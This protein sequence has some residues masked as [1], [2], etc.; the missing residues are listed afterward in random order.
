MHPPLTCECC[1]LSL[2]RDAPASTTHASSASTPPA[3]PTRLSLDRLLQHCSVASRGPCSTGASAGT[4]SQS[5]ERLSRRELQS[6]GIKG[7]QP[8]K[9]LRGGTA[10]VIAG[11]KLSELSSELGAGLIASPWSG[12]DPSRLSESGTSSKVLLLHGL[13]LLIQPCLPLLVLVLLL[14]L[15]L[16]R[17]NRAIADATLL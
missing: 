13:Q 14:L 8:N 7:A 12:E 10:A 5:R 6:A 16:S 2:F 3:Y 17:L 9:P 1:R 15:G 4:F 11:L